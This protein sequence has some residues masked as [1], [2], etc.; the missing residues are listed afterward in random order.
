MKNEKDDGHLDPEEEQRFDFHP[1]SNH[2]ESQNN[3]LRWQGYLFN[4]NV[5]LS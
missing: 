2:S 4:W 1:N 5:G 3:R